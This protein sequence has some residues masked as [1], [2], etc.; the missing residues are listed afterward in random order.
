M[1]DV[2]VPGEYPFQWVLEGWGWNES[3][4]IQSFLTFNWAFEVV[5]GVQWL[6]QN[7]PEAMEDAAPALA[8]ILTKPGSSFWMR[9]TLDSRPSG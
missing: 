3:Y 5:L 7:Q 9:R 1:H 8:P 6:V 4:L 2:F